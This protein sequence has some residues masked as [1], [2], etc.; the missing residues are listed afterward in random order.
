LQKILGRRRRGHNVPLD[1]GRLLL[2][3]TT[4][5]FYLVVYVITNNQ[6]IPWLITSPI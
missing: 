2:L 3:S 4:F 1:I 6:I 5:P